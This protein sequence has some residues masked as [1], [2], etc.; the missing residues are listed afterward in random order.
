MKRYLTLSDSSDLDF[1]NT[2]ATGGFISGTALIF[3]ILIWTLISAVPVDIS[4]KCTSD[5]AQGIWG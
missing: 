5:L 2:N 1:T 3:S 4:W